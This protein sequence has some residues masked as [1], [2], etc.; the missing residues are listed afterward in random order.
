MVTYAVNIKGEKENMK[1]KREYI[2]INEQ[3][4][5]ALSASL[6]HQ[7]VSWKE[8]SI[9]EWQ[10]LFHMA[11]QQQVLPLIYEAVCTCPAAKKEKKFLQAISKQ[12]FQEVARQV[13]KTD[14]FLQIYEKLCAAGVKPLVIK[15]LICRSLY[16]KPD[17]RPSTDED[18]FIPWEQFKVA[19]QVMMDA[20]MQ[21]LEPENDIYAEH[22]VPY[23]KRGTFLYVEMHKSLFPHQNDAYGEFNHFFKGVHERAIQENI[24]G[25]TVYTMEYTDH[26]FYLICHAF[27]HF[28]GSGFG[29]RPIC[30]IVLFANTYGS[31]ID[32]ERV[33]NC[34]K[35]IHAEKLIAAA[36]QIGRKY[37]GFD[38]VKACLPKEWK[39][40]NVDETILLEDML[41][42]GVLGN[43]SIDRLHS[44]TITSNAVVAQKRGEKAKS[45]IIKTV[46]P[47]V[48]Y[49]ARNY[50]YLDKYP[51]LL[52]IA[53]M[54]RVVKYG[55]EM[56]GYKKSSPSKSIE[57]GNRRIELMK[58]YGV[59]KEKDDRVSVDSHIIN[60]L[61]LLRYSLNKE[62]EQNLPELEAP[63]DWTVMETWAK[64]HHLLPIFYDV[65]CKYP[66]YSER[67]D[68]EEILNQVFSIV[69]QQIKRT[70]TFLKVYREF[71][72]EDLHPIVMKGLICRQLYGKDAE[73]RPSSDEDILV[74]VDDFYRVKEV[75][76]H[77]GF[78]CSRPDVTR[79]QL[80]QLQ[81][82]AFYEKESGFLIEVHTNIMGHA[83]EMR[84]K[85]GDCFNDVFKYARIVEIRN[86]QITTMSHTEHFLF[87]V[88]H[89]FKHFVLNGVGV[90]QMLDILLYQKTYEQEIDWGFVKTALEENRA[91]QYLGD[92]QF[93]GEKYLGFEFDVKFGICDPHEL[94]QDMMDVGV[95]GKQEKSDILAAGI[96]FGSIDKEGGM[97]R[98]VIR[99]AFPEKKYVMVSVPHLKEKPWLLP[100]EWVKRWGRFLKKS[101]QYNGNLVMDSM[102]KSQKRMK[103]LRKYGL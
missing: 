93:V 28:L 17:H 32:W 85:M 33:L 8:L 48:K 10:A 62:C 18:I 24:Q 26:L 72:K 29:V 67:T 36:F 34:C 56:K 68:D 79:E 92:L 19:H 97:I 99:M 65:A 25:M 102:K 13:M 7:T 61:K 1:Q 14:Q 71:L 51:Y 101:K 63:T 60:F 23:I 21:L 16:L 41:E 40:I 87:L 46:F 52:P 11:S 12:V 91:E 64:S 22:E 66:E 76:E 77:Q 59:I 75:L 39:E 81:D 20:G 100:V 43:S 96:N 27:K 6:K 42:G 69:G 31:L 44:S 83:N 70:E 3:F 49:M 98:L 15:G 95:F 78:R 47:P 37:F 73:K 30:D 88:L 4:L 84:T 80:K 90:R 58:E 45:N 82:V 74:R 94:L 2:N 38:D 50:K 86:V 53:W 55:Q 9:S 35:E 103:L 54:S 57:I 89:A 5:E